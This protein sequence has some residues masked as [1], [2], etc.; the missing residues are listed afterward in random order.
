MVKEM[1]NRLEKNAERSGVLKSLS[2]GKK[3]TTDSPPVPISFFETHSNKIQNS[4]VPIS[5]V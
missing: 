1:V 2:I 4:C 3:K 5:N